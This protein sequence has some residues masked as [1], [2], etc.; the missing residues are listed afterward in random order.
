MKN[1]PHLIQ[2]LLSFITGFAVKHL[3]EGYSVQEK[4]LFFSYFYAQLALT[5]KEAK[6]KMS[7]LFPTI[8]A[9][10][11]RVKG[12]LTSELLKE[13]AIGIEHRVVN[14]SRCDNTISWLYQSLK[15][16][17]EKEA[18]KKV[19]ANNH[20]L[21]GKDVLY[22]TQFFTDEYMVKHLVERCINLCDGR[23]DNLVFID[24]AMGGGNFLSYVFVALFDWYSTNTDWTPSIIAKTI[25]DNQIVGYDL[26]NTLPEIAALSLYINACT[27]ANDI[28][29]SSL[30]YFGG[31]EDDMLGF[32]GETIISNSINGVTFNQYWKNILRSNKRIVYVTNPPFM[33][34]RDMD[35]TLKEELQHNYPDTKGDLCFSFMKKIL[36]HLRGNDILA[37]VSQNGW[38]NL[39]SMKHLRRYLL[40]S[41]FLESC[42]DLGSNS[43][44]AINGEK[45]N[46]VLA[47]FING[48]FPDM[49]SSF[50]NLR[51]LSYTEKSSIVSDP[52]ELEKLA[53]RVSQND[54]DSNPSLEY[55]YELVNE[56]QSLNSLPKYSDFAKPMQGSSTGN[57]KEFV[58]YAWEPETADPSWRLVSKGG[59]LSKWQGLNIYKVLWGN[60][61]E[62]IASNKGSALRNIKEIPQTQLVYS[63]TGTLGLSVRRLLPN[64]V[65]IASGPGIKVNVGDPLCHMAF[66]NSK[67]AGCLLK[68]KNPKFT[69]SAGYIGALPVRESVLFSSEIAGLADRAMVL[70]AKYLKSK[71]PNTEFSH[72]DYSR[73]TD[74]MEYVFAAIMEDVFNQMERLNIEIE[75]D[76]IIL[77]EYNFNNK[78]RALLQEMIG[79][80]PSKSKNL[81][82][83]ELDNSL[84]DLLSDGCT[85]SGR[86]LNGGFIGSENFIEIL[87]YQFGCEAKQIFSLIKQDITLFSKTIEKYKYDLIHKL[88]LKGCGINNLQKGISI[89]IEPSEI[90]NRLYT[91]WPSLSES[92]GVNTTLVSDIILNTHNRCFMGKPI[93]KIR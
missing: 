43:F 8:A 62:R 11:S 54:F 46:V 24:P 39:S 63:D 57:S 18:F 10:Y 42:V 45:T 58:K 6:E 87:S 82:V 15:K 51:S 21:S 41:C 4:S 93:I 2:G 84:Y 22:T 85:P 19:G 7:S 80:P 72:Y 36:I 37:L 34:K 31:K 14:S 5:D 64:Q 81:F 74:W 79:L 26:D 77:Q 49:Q 28:D 27:R 38:M 73:I 89:S 53:I 55:S 25:I 29:F 59:G 9:A 60:N 88:V 16:V 17:F 70:K 30:Q 90:V 66:L 65:F 91:T 68:I 3:G 12:E 47:V 20:K 56:F 83:E 67:I 35:V 86:K 13:L 71:L 76:S 69:I 50:Y 92:L 33:G 40:D 78:Q 23:I 44:F 75:I 61:G 52:S 1:N 32:M 48:L